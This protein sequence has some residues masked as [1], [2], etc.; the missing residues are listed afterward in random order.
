VGRGRRLAQ[1][2]LSEQGDPGT[3]LGGAKVGDRKPAGR[4]GGG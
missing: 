2:I 1:L 4:T 3:S